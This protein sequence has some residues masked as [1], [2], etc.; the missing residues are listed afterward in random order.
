MLLQSSTAFM[1]ALTGRFWG[2]DE[3]SKP[4]PLV[5]GL[6]CSTNWNLTAAQS[7][8]LNSVLS[9]TGDLPST[10]VISAESLWIKKIVSLSKQLNGYAL[11]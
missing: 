3:K 9:T 4:N 7:T 8:N 10:A 2:C 1:Q 5:R 6:A 11:T